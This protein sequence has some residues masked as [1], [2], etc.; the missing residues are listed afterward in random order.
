M[1]FATKSHVGNRG[2]GTATASQDVRLKA[3]LALVSIMKN[4]LNTK[5]QS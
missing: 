2:Y 3:A 5:Q 1:L 4:D